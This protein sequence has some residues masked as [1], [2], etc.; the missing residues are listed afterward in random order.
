MNKIPNFYIETICVKLK[1]KNY[2]AQNVN[3]TKVEK[4]YL[5]GIHNIR[6]G[7]GQ[8]CSIDLDKEMEI[9]KVR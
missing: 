4:P 8:L 6:D 1:K 7:L 2:P 3:R 9:R 5:R